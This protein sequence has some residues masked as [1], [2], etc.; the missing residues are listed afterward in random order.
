MGQHKAARSRAVISMAGFDADDCRYLRQSIRC[1][2]PS[3]EFGFKG[4]SN[5]LG[6]IGSS[7][8]DVLECRQILWGNLLRQ[9]QSVEHGGNAEPRVDPLTLNPLSNP[10]RVYPVHDDW[11]ANGL[12]GQEGAGDLQ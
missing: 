2:H 6:Q 10:N 8:P 12:S 7:G 11:G 4:T 3:A 1:M 9:C 5:R